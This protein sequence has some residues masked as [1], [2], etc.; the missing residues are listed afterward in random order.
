[1]NIEEHTDELE[2][3]L[4]LKSQLAASPLWKRWIPQARLLRVLSCPGDYFEKIEFLFQRRRGESV[5]LSTLDCLLIEVWARAGIPLV[6]ALRGIDAAF[7][8]YS[9]RNGQF[10]VKSINSLRYCR[11]AVYQAAEAM[12]EASVGWRT[13]AQAQRPVTGKTLLV[14]LPPR[15][16]VIFAALQSRAVLTT[17]I[18]IQDMGLAFTC[19][20]SPGK[21]F[22]QQ[23]AK[24]LYGVDLD[25]LEKEEQSCEAS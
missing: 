13:T 15:G 21:P 2:H 23:R 6:A 4:L 12:K 11:Q 22:I 8:C 14:A 7:H 19:F 16:A 18:S 5:L 20:P 17:M 10:S 1:V 25:F 24:D 9:V 3:W